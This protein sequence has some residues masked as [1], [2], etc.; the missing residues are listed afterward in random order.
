MKRSTRVPA[1]TVVRMKSASNRIAKWYQIPISVGPPRKDDRMLAIPAASVGAPPVRDMIVVSP[2]SLAIWAISLGVYKSPGRDHLC[3]LLRGGANQ[4]CRAVH[5]K[6]D[7]GMNDAGPDHRHD[8]DERLHQHCA[9]ADERDL[10]FI[11]DHF[12]CGSRCD[13]RMPSR[14]RSA[15]D[16]DEQEREHAAGPNGSGAVDELCYGRHLQIG[17]NDDDADGK[18]RDGANLKEGREIVA[19][20]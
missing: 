10:A 6:V 16:G 19:R 2:T 4:P 1:S 15:G 13:E 9:V 20:R 17:T 11:L 18:Q 8:R 3:G 12:R 14:N 5:R 7:A